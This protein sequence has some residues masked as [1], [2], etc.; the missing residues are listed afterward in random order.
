MLPLQGVGGD[1][2]IGDQ[3]ALCLE[4]GCGLCPMLLRN[5]HR[6]GAPALSSL[7]MDL[8]CG[9]VHR[10]GGTRTH[11]PRNPI[12]VRYQIA[13]LPDEQGYYSRAG[14]PVKAG[15]LRVTPGGARVCTG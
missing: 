6:N 5:H 15:R 10:G 2:R 9:E 3:D 8:A 7:G 13:P 11:N 1:K 12:P 4:E 14:A